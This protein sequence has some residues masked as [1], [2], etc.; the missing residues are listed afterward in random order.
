[1]CIYLSHVL[2]LPVFEYVQVILVISLSAA[3][4]TTALSIDVFGVPGLCQVI[5]GVSGDKYLLRAII[6]QLLPERKI[7]P[8]ENG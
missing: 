5:S 7:V 6:R 4:R 3:V 2:S 1:M 8:E